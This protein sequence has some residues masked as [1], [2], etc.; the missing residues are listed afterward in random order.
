MLC[1]SELRSLRDNVPMCGRVVGSDDPHASDHLPV[2][3]TLDL[4]SDAA[5][6]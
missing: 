5:K 1:F 2:L 6:L 3:I 4:Q